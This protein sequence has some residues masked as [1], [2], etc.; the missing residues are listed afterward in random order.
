LSGLD[1]KIMTNAKYA[2]YRQRTKQLLKIA[3]GIYDAE[4]RY[5]IERAICELEVLTIAAPRP[6]IL[7]AA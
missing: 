7:A 2:A 4:E 5:L 6:H 3:Q 1:E